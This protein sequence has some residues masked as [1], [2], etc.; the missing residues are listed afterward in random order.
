MQKQIASGSPKSGRAPDP[1]VPPRPQRRTFTGEYKMRILDEVERARGQPGA[2][3]AILRREAL[4]S[5]T[6]VQWRKERRRGSLEAMSKKRG[7]KPTRQPHADQLA[8]LRRENAKLK[9]RL[10]QAEVIIDIQKK[11]SSM[12]GIPLTTSDDDEN[13]F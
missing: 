8:R 7:R 2:I 11:I 4:Y 12:L 10:A 3:T 6:L 9:E 5:S 1:E 13:D